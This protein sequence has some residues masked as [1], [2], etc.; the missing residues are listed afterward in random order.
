ML[1]QINNTPL[2]N[3]TSIRRYWHLER[4][5]DLDGHSIHLHGGVDLDDQLDSYYLHKI[6][7][8]EADIQTGVALERVP[9]AVG[10]KFIS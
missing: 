5:K 2:I 7:L 4:I 8:V 6:L 10:S 9:R 1:F 3:K